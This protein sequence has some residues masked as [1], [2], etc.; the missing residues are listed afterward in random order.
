MCDHVVGGAGGLRLLGQSPGF[1]VATEPVERLRPEPGYH[2]EPSVLSQPHQIGD[3]VEGDLRSPRGIARRELDL[4]L[5]HRHSRS[6]QELPA[7]P[8]LSARRNT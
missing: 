7:F 5:F 1:L 2:R 3:P 6:E 8:R 4:G